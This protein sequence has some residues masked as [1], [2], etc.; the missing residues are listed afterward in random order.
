VDQRRDQAVTLPINIPDAA[1]RRPML[2]KGKRTDA[3]MTE[4]LRPLLAHNPAHDIGIAEILIR[5]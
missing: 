3:T 5:V 1:D 2:L 4:D